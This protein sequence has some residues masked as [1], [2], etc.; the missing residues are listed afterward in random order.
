MI[1]RSW[2]GIVP[3]DKAGAFRLYLLQTGVTEAKS[4]PGNLGAFI[5]SQPQGG[6][7]H[8]FMVSYWIDM[9]A[10]C[11]FAGLM[12][13]IAVTYPDDAKY[14][15]ISDP[16]ALHHEVKSVPEDFPIPIDLDNR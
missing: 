10:V 6:W 8:F 11:A 7:E 12:P 4:T 9:E 13:H 5:Y 1:V 14:G 3:I 15:L 2:H 16:I